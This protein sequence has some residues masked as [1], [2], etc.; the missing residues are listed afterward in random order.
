MGVV[1]TNEVF[2]ETVKTQDV[3]AVFDAVL[4]EYG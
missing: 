2:A 4:G 3:A 1:L